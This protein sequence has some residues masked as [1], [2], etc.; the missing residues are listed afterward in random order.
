MPPNHGQRSAFITYSP[1][2]ISVSVISMSKKRLASMI[3]STVSF[4]VFTPSCSRRSEPCF[5]PMRVIASLPIFCPS[6]P[7]S[8]A[9][10]IISSSITPVPEAAAFHLYQV[11]PGSPSFIA[12]RARNSGNF[13]NPYTFNHFMRSVP[14]SPSAL[15]II[16]VALLIRFQRLVFYRALTLPSSTRPFLL[17]DILSL[18]NLTVRRLLKRVAFSRKKR[19]WGRWNGTNG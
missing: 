19:L 14:F 11:G 16:L 18:G 4:I 3:T 8:S 2:L 17:L 13:G 7:R 15:L 9:A 10:R 12:Q 6:Y 5:S 1:S